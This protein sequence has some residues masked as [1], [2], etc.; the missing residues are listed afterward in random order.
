MKRSPNSSRS[1]KWIVRNSLNND[2][3]KRYVEKLCIFLSFKYFKFGEYDSEE[4][5]LW[6]TYG[7]KS[8]IVEIDKENIC[9][10]ILERNNY[11][12]DKDRY[13][14][15]DKFFTGDNCWY[16]CLNWIKCRI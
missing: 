1:I 9:L 12:S 14:L 16:E 10:K 13:Y 4:Q 15:L 2:N 11:F 3:C 6:I 8:Y 7:T 5:A